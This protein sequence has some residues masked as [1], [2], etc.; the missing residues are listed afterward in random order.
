MNICY[1]FLLHIYCRQSLNKIPKYRMENF[2]RV[3][4]ELR[5][6]ADLSQSELARVTDISQS[7]ISRIENGEIEIV[8]LSIKE[9]KSL[10]EVL[11]YDFLNEGSKKLDEL[12]GGFD[13]TWDSQMGNF[14]GKVEG[15]VDYLRNY[16]NE[17]DSLTES[18]AEFIKFC[19]ENSI[20]PTA[21]TRGDSD[22][23]KS[24]LLNKLI[25]SDI[26]SSEFAP[27]TGVITY[28]ISDRF[29]LY[30]GSKV[31][32]YNESFSYENYFLGE[33]QEEHLIDTGNESLLESCSIKSGTHKEIE[34]ALVFSDAE[35]LESLVLCD[36]PGTGAE[37]GTNDEDYKD[38]NRIRKAS[39][40]C[41][42]LLFLSTAT[43]YMKDS[44]IIQFKDALSNLHL[45][46][47]L[48][49]KKNP[50]ENVVLV[51]THSGYQTDAEIETI[52]SEAA[53]RIKSSIGE[54]SE[55]RRIE[56]FVG[57]ELTSNDFKERMTP[58][59]YQKSSRRVELEKILR[60]LVEDKLTQA[61]IKEKEEL[62]DKYSNSVEAKTKQK[63]DYYNSLINEKE[64][65]QEIFD[66]LQKEEPHRKKQVA[67]SKELVHSKIDSHLA[68]SK[69]EWNSICKE[70]L[71]TGK[72]EQ[73][74]RKEFN[75]RKKAKNSVASYVVNKMNDRLKD[76][77]YEESL[78]FKD[79]V[80]EYIGNYESN[81]VLGVDNNDGGVNEIGFDPKAAFAGGLVGF[82][83]IGALAVWASTLGNLG[84]YIITAKL[85]S[86]LS[87]LGISV[88]AGAF[89]AFV[90]VI[91][92][93]VTIFVALGV[94]IATA[95]YTIFGQSWQTR[96]SKKIKSAIESKD[97]ASKTEKQHIEK[98]WSDT[99]SA[100][101]AGAEA[102]EMEYQQNLNELGDMLDNYDVN[103]LEESIE[104]FEE[105]INFIKGAPSITST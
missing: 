79:T 59:W 26:L 51:M 22:S 92:G 37:T 66:R 62:I 31:Q 84:G 53:K 14:H 34:F 67:L 9:A 28:I 54:L 50:L 12:I 1:S 57:R 21:L 75:S 87:A 94:I 47:G 74:I 7:H 13:D 100:F 36:T 16:E 15:L 68:N 99:R 85:L 44:E 33:K 95:V 105:F 69:N 60:E 6:K 17:N 2:G 27:E 10:E 41:D 25:G 23:A 70:Y 42:L 32:L 20:P 101:E 86:I 30:P 49:T 46:K 81:E 90:A 3:V 96:L 19:K 55:I 40:N 38:I 88:G 8:E 18:I 71:D 97:Y 11:G 48:L 65:K 77:I 61:Y 93:P 35:I 80:Y 5:I 103:S 64:K 73:I 104:A 78:K 98:Y 24:Y 63:I 82:G 43:G 29:N 72:I 45:Y 76:V 52:K 56:E 91:G 83:A 58:F 89:S 39:E 4:K 102:L